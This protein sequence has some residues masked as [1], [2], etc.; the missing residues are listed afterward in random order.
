MTKLRVSMGPNHK[1]SLH[2]LKGDLMEIS[3]T[4]IQ[5]AWRNYRT[6]S[7]VNNYTRVFNHL[8]IPAKSYEYVGS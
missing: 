6:R 3:A 2:K 7:L 5:R 8:G 1:L 4:I